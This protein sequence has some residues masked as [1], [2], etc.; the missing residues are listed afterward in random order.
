M[1]SRSS[2]RSIA[3]VPD[4]FLPAGLLHQDPPHRLCRRREEVPPAIP[5]LGFLHV[6]EPDVCL[7]HERR[8]LQS[9]AGLLLGHHLGRQLAQ[10]IVDQR[11]ELL[12]SRGVAL[13]DGGEDTRDVGHGRG[14][15]IRASAHDYATQPGNPP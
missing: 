11:Q 6:H 2:T 5:V 9:L 3:T 7:M 4:T 14:F 1:T 10:L 15:Q 8:G 13:L 12:G